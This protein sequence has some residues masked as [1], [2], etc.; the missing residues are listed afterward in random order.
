MPPCILLLILS[1]QVLDWDLETSKTHIRSMQAVDDGVWCA[2]MGG[3]FHYGSGTGFDLEYGYPEELPH[4]EV[5]DILEDSG[6]RLWV[7]TADGL[8]M[9][10]DGIW[11]YYTSF[12]GI[13][14][15]GDIRDVE[16]AGSWIWVSSDGGLAR[17]TGEDFLPMDESVTQGGF[18]AGDASGLE[19]SRD[20]LWIA[21]GEGVFSL[22]LASSPF[23]A[24]SWRDWSDV[25]AGLSIA[26]FHAGQDSLF[27]WGGKGVFRWDGTRWTVLLD[28]STQPD[29]IVSGLLETGDGLLA[30][31]LAVR[32]RNPDGSWGAYG[33]GFPAGTWVTA[34][35]AGDGRI[36]CGAGSEHWSNRDFGRGLGVLEA[37][38]WSIVRIPGHPGRSCYQIGLTG[39]RTYLGSHTSG[40]MAEYQGGW[41][42]FDTDDG[43]PNT[44]RTYSAV[45]SPDGSVWTGSYHYGLTWVSDNGTQQSSD[46]SL[47]TFVSDSLAWA[48]PATV[49]VIAPLF[50]N[51]VVCAAMQGEV[52]WVGQ[53]A[54]WSTPDEPSGI[55]ACQGSP[56]AGAMQWAG[57]AEA[58]GLAQ[59]NVRAILPDGADGI[60]IAFTGDGGCQRLDHSG[61][62][63]DPSDDAWLPGPGMAFTTSSGL[64][65]NQVFCFADDGTGG[66]LAGTGAG[67]AA[68]S[69]AQGFREVGDIP[70]SVK[71]I[72]LDGAGRIWCLGTSAIWCVED[73]VTTLWD[74]SNSPFL[75]A[76]RVENEFGAWDPQ[77][78]EVLFSSQSGLWV[79]HVGGGE[80]GS[81]GP[82][83]HPQPFIPAGDG[84]LRVAGTSGGPVRVVFFDLEGRC[85]GEVA[86]GSAASWEWDGTFGG[87]AAA[88]GI[89][90]LLVDDGGA[91]STGK[92]ALLR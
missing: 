55:V 18:T 26:G 64:P 13:P 79:L 34:L 41:E 47:I 35:A 49:Q 76:S 85:L 61:T 24:S 92:V 17:W 53:E 81:G 66:I 30:A 68:W 4:Y 3:V 69:P 58:D 87:T 23:S 9:L 57:F 36:W 77:E 20:T 12:E 70:G 54:F 63:F 62:P 44:L 91:V 6:G 59:K 51:Q 52:L 67:L 14:G 10:E 33:S 1:A 48:P 75:P 60:W 11:T 16:Q 50:N 32:R 42:S 88:S 5:H 80:G 8:A 71:A 78:G 2:T 29:S 56:V 25:S 40:L 27:A 73:G 19:V 37:G 39:G 15:S 82:S 46:D 83:F 89:Y 22:D 45:P 84:A 28:Y 86:A 90:I 31:A 7:A 38:Q 43:L 72:V 74:E 21:T 65:S